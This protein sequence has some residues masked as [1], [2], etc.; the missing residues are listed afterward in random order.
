MALT[1][2][3]IAVFKRNSHAAAHILTGERSVEKIRELALSLVENAK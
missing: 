3:E 2:E 1:A